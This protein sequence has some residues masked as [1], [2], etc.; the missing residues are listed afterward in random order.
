MKSGLRVSEKVELANTAISTAMVTVMAMKA[1]STTCME[2]IKKWQLNGRRRLHQELSFKLIAL[3]VCNTVCAR[4][5][6]KPR[7]AAYA[8]RYLV[9]RSWLTFGSHFCNP[10]EVGKREIFRDYAFISICGETLAPAR[11][12]LDT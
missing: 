2:L 12:F 8:T 5:R 1:N 7:L 9:F 11:Y 3:Q 4:F 10:E 6:Q